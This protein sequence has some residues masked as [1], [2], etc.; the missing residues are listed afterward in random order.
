MTDISRWP[1]LASHSG[2]LVAVG[3][4]LVVVVGVISTA[5]SV[6]LSRRSQG[7]TGIRQTSGLA[8]RHHLG[9]SLADTRASRST[10]FLASDLCIS[11]NHHVGAPHEDPVTAAEVA[12]I[13]TAF[14]EQRLASNRGEADDEA[15]VEI[16]LLERIWEISSDAEDCRP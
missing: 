5:V 6:L 1:A 10:I 7:T 11:I 8:W 14:S 13:T 3:L 2:F 15:R 4:A 16:L 12:A 9:C